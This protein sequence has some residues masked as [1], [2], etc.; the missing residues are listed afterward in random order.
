MRT[1]SSESHA[2]T[3]MQT[4]AGTFVGADV[5]L[6][7]LPLALAAADRYQERELLGRGGMGE[8]RLVLDKTI[9]RE[10][11]LKVMRGQPDAD[12]V[13]RF[14]REARVQGQ[15]E[16]PAIVPVHELAS[17]GAGG[18]YFTMK[19]VRGRTLRQL[20]DEGDLGRRRLL[21]AFSTACLA[22]HFAHSRG[23][24]HRDLKP[25]NLMLGDFGEVYV[26]DWGLAKLTGAALAESI[27]PRPA[28]PL[29]EMTHTA[30]GT[31]MGTPGY[32]APEQVRGA[33]ASVATEIYALGS[34]LF[35]LLT[36]ERL[37]RADTVEGL[38]Q[39]TL[40]GSAIGARMEGGGAIGARMDG[41]PPELEAICARATADSADDRY[42]SARDL[43]QAVE[44]FLDGEH[45][46]ERR[47]AQAARHAG[48]ARAAL[49]EAPDDTATR[50][51]VM[52]EV[53]TA[54]GLDPHNGD[55]VRTLVQ[56]LTE[57]P[58]E[59]PPEAQAEMAA[60]LRATQTTGARA[61]VVAY[62]VL[63]L[64]FVPLLLWMGVR[65]WRWMGVMV[66][67]CA[68][69]GLLSLWSAL[70][71]GVDGRAPLAGILVSHV[72]MAS[73]SLVF[74]PFIVVPM[75]VMANTGGII[76]STNRRRRKLVLALGAL[77]IAVPFALEWCGILPQ[78][79]AFQD[80]HL[81]VLPVATYLPPLA[82]TVYL[83]VASVVGV[84]MLGAFLGRFRDSQLEAERRLYLH[85]WQLKQIVPEASRPGV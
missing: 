79:Y 53:A 39:S 63:L 45:D 28:V 74:G 40:A 21:S 48:A 75:M 34:I 35:E 58:R 12:L 62:L 41:V 18:L 6:A 24:L 5:D 29:P 9:G 72:A 83:L 23:V 78:H 67:I 57:P 46:L 44:E 16:H 43:S 31:I 54:L 47:Q 26:L 52:R 76:A 77:A 22:M 30:R 71:P 19:R 33:G 68:C 15:L 84:V 81:M 70:S 66:A 1:M 7:Q 56:L 55:A 65:D 2:P 61:S 60:S 36:G 69:S 64:A 8:V 11:A 85:S 49:A 25:Q 82:T 80:G 27:P 14:L 17:D 38:L 59:L 50:G 37:H 20:I 4:P 3:L 10:V 42:S 73:A 51:R 32:M 13:Q